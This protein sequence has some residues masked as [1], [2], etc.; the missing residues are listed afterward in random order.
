LVCDYSAKGDG[1]SFWKETINKNA[2]LQ[3]QNELIAL[4]PFV[5]EKA[6]G[7]DQ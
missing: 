2:D 1:Y 5:N 7:D 6:L 3:V 4:V